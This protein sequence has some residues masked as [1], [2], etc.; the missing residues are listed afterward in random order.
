MHAHTVASQM[1][2]KGRYVQVMRKFS[3]RRIIVVTGTPRS[4]TTAVGAVLDKAPG[5]G[6]IHEPMNRDSGDKCVRQYFEMP[7]RDGFEVELFHDLVHRV[8]NLDLNLHAGHFKGEHFSRRILKSLVGGRTK[9]S[10]YRC[11]LQRNLNTIIWKDPFLL[12]CLE[13]FLQRYDFPVIVC[14]RS[15]LA[16]AASFKRLNWKYNAVRIGKRLEGRYPAVLEPVISEE[17][18][19]NPAYRGAYFWLYS[20]SYVLKLVEKYRTLHLL[21]IDEVINNPLPTYKSIFHKLDLEYTEKVEDYLVKTLLKNPDKPP[22]DV[23]EDKTHARNRDMKMINNY[24]RKTLSSDEISDI[25][26]MCTGKENEF[27]KYFQNGC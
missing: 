11:R 15:P 4:G 25:Q 17:K 2:L 6:A 18:F 22:R 5:T 10:Y 16:I 23:P 21:N 14:Y 12:F 8:Q 24:W 13:E 1:W 3:H 9:Q 19:N 26:S 7:G 20:Y 27:R